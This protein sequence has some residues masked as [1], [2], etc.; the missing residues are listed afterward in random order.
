M[1]DLVRQL[2]PDVFVF[3]NVPGL[4]SAKHREFFKHIID[5][6]TKDGTYNVAFK[7][8]DAI[9][10]G[11]PQHRKRLFTIGCKTSSACKTAQQI[12][13]DITQSAPTFKASSSLKTIHDV[14]VHVNDP[15]VH[16]QSI[17][18]ENTV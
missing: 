5:D 1:P 7:V 4:L 16:F 17:V 11:V 3:E 8:L 18:Y 2:N 15:N 14:I 10:F 9:D 12:L 13:D 6:F